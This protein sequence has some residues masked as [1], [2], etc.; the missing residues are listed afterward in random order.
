MI[1]FKR[2]YETDQFGAGEIKGD[3]ENAERFCPDRNKEVLL[4]VC[5]G[6]GK[7]YLRENI[8]FKI[9]FVILHLRLFEIR[10]A[11]KKGWRLNKAERDFINLNF[12]KNSKNII[13][14]MREGK[15]QEQI[16]R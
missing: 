13:A 7:G 1:I 10:I 11:E 4:R 14:E 12:K 5:S 3:E 9:L 16:F 8:E 2:G 6:N 15:A